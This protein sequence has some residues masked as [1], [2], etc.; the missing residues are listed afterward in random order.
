LAGLVAIVP[1]IIVDRYI[2]DDYRTVWLVLPASVYLIAST[3]IVLVLLA[4]RPTKNQTSSLMGERP[5]RM[6]LLASSWILMPAV[7]L[8]L[9]VVGELEHLFGGFNPYSWT[10]VLLLGVLAR[11][12]S[13]G[14]YA[15]MVIDRETEV[16]RREGFREYDIPRGTYLV[17][18][19]K[20]DAAFSLFSDLTS[21]PLR[22][23]AVV[24]GAEISASETLLYL[25]PR[26]LIITREFPE[27]VRQKHNL[28]I[29][30]II[31]LTESP[32]EK[33]I[34]PTSL[35]MLTD[36]I[37]RFME[38]NPNS[39]ILLEGIEY[40]CTFND[41]KK[42]LRFLDTLN[43]SAWVTKARL[44]LTVDP[45]AFAVKDIALLERDR[46]IIRGPE[47]LEDL[48]VESRVHI[49][50]SGSPE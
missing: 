23:D 48:K 17:H 29:T 50:A 6:M 44:I 40:I 45:R 13:M 37:V 31:W 27:K 30:P 20:S 24:P 19:E 47:G 2:H 9:G 18:D 4:R 3:A 28:Q 43:E 16:V 12:I 33:R 10:L 49:A 22:P 42:V 35:S 32:G 25:I 34:A 7:V 11:G 5:P 14:R 8:T 36:T 39:I 15:A 38:T 41:F 1:T 21:L 46:T 26:G